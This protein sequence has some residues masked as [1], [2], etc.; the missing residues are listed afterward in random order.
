MSIDKA[1]KVLKE[2]QSW[3][4]GNRP[5]F[6]YQPREVTVALNRVLGCFQEPEL[7]KKALAIKDYRNRM[8]YDQVSMGKMLKISQAR[9]SKIENGKSAVDARTWNEFEQILKH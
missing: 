5:T 9:L 7:S 3:R 4:L 8:N 6:P 1:L 2:Y